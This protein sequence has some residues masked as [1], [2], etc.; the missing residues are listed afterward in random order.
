VIEISDFSA[1]GEADST[2]TYKLSPYF[3]QSGFIE[4]DLSGYQ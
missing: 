2:R 4:V 1:R 3:H